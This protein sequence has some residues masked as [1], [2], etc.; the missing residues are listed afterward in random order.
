MNGWSH[1]NRS[2]SRRRILG[3]RLGA[4]APP[5]PAHC[6]AARRARFAGGPG[7]RPR[8]RAVRRQGQAGAA[9]EGHRGPEG[10]GRTAQ[11]APD[12]PRRRDQARPPTSSRASTP[13]WPRSR[14]RSPAWQA[15]ID[16]IKTDYDALVGPARDARRAAR[17]DRGP[18]GG[19]AHR[20]RR[21]Q[22]A[23]GRPPPQ[24]LRHGPHL[25]PRVVPVGRHVHRPAGRDERLHRRRRAGQGAR[26]SRSPRTRRRSPRSTRRRSTRAPR[27]DDLRQQTA[28]QKRALDKSLAAAQ[29]GQGALKKLE[30]R[31]ASELA[32]AEARLR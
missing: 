31:V 28:A 26:R 14:S 10:A 4:V 25:A 11:R 22:G 8:R 15:K 1:P 12:R 19:Q 2:A 6:R 21:A 23:P 20:A 29:R 9:Q 24:R 27:T 16:V 18:G 7:H 13:T 3:R 5:L 30:K 32:T 17:R